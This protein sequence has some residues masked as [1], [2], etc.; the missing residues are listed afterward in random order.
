MQEVKRTLRSGISYQN[1]TM[2]IDLEAKN[3]REAPDEHLMNLKEPVTMHLFQSKKE[4][5]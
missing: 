2:P 5:K 4:E 3:T 1:P